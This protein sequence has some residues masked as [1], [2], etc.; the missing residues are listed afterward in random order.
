MEESTAKVQHSHVYVSSEQKEKDLTYPIYSEKAEGGTV[1]SSSC[2][3][4]YIIHVK[5][6]QRSK[7]DENTSMEFICNNY[8]CLDNFWT[9]DEMIL[10][11]E[12]YTKV[13]KSTDLLCQTLWTPMTTKRTKSLNNLRQKK[14]RK[15]LIHQF[16]S[17]NYGSYTLNLTRPCKGKGEGRIQ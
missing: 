13:H 9:F 2:Q 5:T 7:Y 3:S 15:G 17:S 8:Q 6:D 12:R 11:M 16:P 10:D 4:G 1:E 14:P